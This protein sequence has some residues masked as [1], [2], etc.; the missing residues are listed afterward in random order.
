[1]LLLALGP[2]RA[3]TAAALLPSSECTAAAAAAAAGRLGLALCP[4]RARAC[5]T[6]WTAE[7]RGVKGLAD[8]K[9]AVALAGKHAGQDS[10]VGNT[11][12][13]GKVGPAAA[14]ALNDRLLSQPLPLAQA[15]APRQGCSSI[16]S[17]SVPQE[18]GFL[19]QD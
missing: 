19:H 2:Q 10:A 16:L 3:F 17:A 18:G 15:P 6:Q 11:D 8:F 5:A 13:T 4:D 12:L 1:M 7:E 9:G 14:A